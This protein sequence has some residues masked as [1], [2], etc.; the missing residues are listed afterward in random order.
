MATLLLA[1]DRIKVRVLCKC[2]DQVSTNVLHWRTRVIAAGPVTTADVAARLDGLIA[3]PLRAILSVDATYVAVGVSRY[4]PLPPTVE[5]TDIT[6]T[7]LGAAGNG[8]ALPTQICGIVTKLTANAGRKWRGRIYMPFP[9]EASNGLNG[10]PEVAYVAGLAAVGTVM[11]GFFNLLVGAAIY[12]FDPVL[13]ASGTP[14]AINWTVLA[15]RTVR[16]VWA[17]QRSRG[18]YGSSP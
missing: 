14:D 7:G 2:R 12:E 8:E 15:G 11:T 6:G 4:W 18:S 13:Q 9:G 1:G 10:L 17:T 3:A 5:D 16:T